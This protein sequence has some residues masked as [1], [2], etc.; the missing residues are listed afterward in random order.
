MATSTSKAMITIFIIFTILLLLFITTP[1]SAASGRV[2]IVPGRPLD[3]NHPVC[4]RGR[5]ER[6]TIPFYPPK[7]P[8][9][10]KYYCQPPAPNTDAALPNMEKNN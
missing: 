7:R 3:P 9:R 6:C 5:G 2:G 4:N 10:Y 8:C 1:A